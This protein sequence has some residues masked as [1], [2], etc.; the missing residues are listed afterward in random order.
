[1]NVLILG[2]FRSDKMP[3]SAIDIVDSRVIS[4]TRLGNLLDFGQLFIAF[5]SN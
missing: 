3:W 5:G 1:M 2:P 4:V